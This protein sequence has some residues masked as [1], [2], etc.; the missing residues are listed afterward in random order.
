MIEK[1]GFFD[2]QF[3]AYGEDVDLSFRAKLTGYRCFYMPAAI[4]YHKINQTMGV[5]SHFVLYYSRQ[6]SIPGLPPC[7]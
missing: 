3:F 1:I 7:K 4:V 6:F 5:K 2:D